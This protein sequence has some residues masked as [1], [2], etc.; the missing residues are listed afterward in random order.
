MQSLREGLSV[1]A[2]HGSGGLTPS[3]AVGGGTEADDGGMLGC[4]FPFLVPLFSGPTFPRNSLFPGILFRFLGESLSSFPYSTRD[5]SWGIPFLGEFLFCT[6][7]P[8]CPNSG[9]LMAVGSGENKKPALI[10]FG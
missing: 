6:F 1:I 7:L 10:L 3:I 5:S 2:V 4:A 8:K 9:S